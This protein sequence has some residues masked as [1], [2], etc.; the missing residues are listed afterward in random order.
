MPLK[1][2]STLSSS[3]TD[4]WQFELKRVY[5][6][7]SFLYISLT[8]SQ[9]EWAIHNYL[10]HFDAFLGRPFWTLQEF[11]EEQS[12][13]FCETG[14]HKKIG[15]KES[16]ILLEEILLSLRME[17]AGRQR[18]LARAFFT[19]MENLKENSPYFLESRFSEFLSSLEKVDSASAPFLK[20]VLEV[21]HQEVEEK[22]FLDRSDMIL[23]FCRQIEKNWD[24]INKIKG[25]TKILI[26]DGLYK[27][28]SVEKA[29]FRRF[30]PEFS[31]V[32]LRVP[33]SSAW[34]K[35]KEFSFIQENLQF[36]QSF[37]FNEEITLMEEEHLA[38]SSLLLFSSREEQK[39]RTVF[40]PKVEFL[41]CPNPFSEVLAMAIEIRRLLDKGIQ[42]SKIGVVFSN[43]FRYFPLVETI[44]SIY[45]LPFQLFMEKAIIQ[46]PVVAFLL[47]LLRLPQVG[48]DRNSL[49]DLLESPFFTLSY[50]VNGKRKVLGNR[51]FIWFDNLVR[52]DGRDLKEWKEGLE[53]LNQMDEDEFQENFSLQE[54]KA[55][56]KSL[57]SF[58][59]ILPSW[60]EEYSLLEFKEK[61]FQIFKI[62]DLESKIY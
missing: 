26:L 6:N 20:N 25:N 51:E 17:K 14:H 41:S 23:Q 16:L 37:F 11:L 61:I 18:G 56:G 62:L 53:E 49:Q 7:S 42:P 9:K 30:L 1:I 33:Y 52:V 55:L 54:A 58:I 45:Q 35:E 40:L 8:R 12:L 31:E 34:K 36:Y 32:I 57:V 59:S 46:V 48:F 2:F 44:F 38:N 5:E 3:H 39:S 24:I 21:Y 47:N 43:T 4:L 19:W 60:N 50:K 28:K 22:G 10:V 15:K 13:L 29:F 27:L